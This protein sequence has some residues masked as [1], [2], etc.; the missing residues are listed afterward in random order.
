MN[1]EEKRKEFME[2]LKVSDTEL[3]VQIGRIKTNDYKKLLKQAQVIGENY[4]YFENIIQGKLYGESFI[5]LKKKNVAEDTIGRNIFTN[6]NRYSIIKTDDRLIYSQE[7]KN[8]NYINTIIDKDSTGFENKICSED[9]NIIEIG[10][11]NDGDMTYSIILRKIDKETNI[12]AEVEFIYSSQNSYIRGEKPV[13]IILLGSNQKESTYSLEDGKYLK[14]GIL[15]GIKNYSF[16]EIGELIKKQNLPVELS[17]I[18]KK[19]ARNEFLLP[20]EF[21]YILRFASASKNI[22]EKNYEDK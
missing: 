17:E 5:C 14:N 18:S 13:K 19:I 8:G 11:N 2:G 10:K 15:K 6:N 12:I 20:E 9:G 7:E 3:K 16:E 4:Y 21:G 22:E 1:S